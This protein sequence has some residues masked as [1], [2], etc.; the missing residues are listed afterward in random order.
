MF[1]NKYLIGVVMHQMVSRGYNVFDMQFA[2]LWI[3]DENGN[4]LD[5]LESECYCIPYR[6]LPCCEYCGEYSCH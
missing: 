2:D 3:C 1:F 4:I 6:G 5:E